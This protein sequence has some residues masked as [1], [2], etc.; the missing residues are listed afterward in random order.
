MGCV[1]KRQKEKRRHHPAV[2]EKQDKVEVVFTWK[3]RNRLRDQCKI[4]GLKQG[5]VKETG[6]GYIHEVED[7]DGMTDEWFRDNEDSATMTANVQLDPGITSL[8][9][10]NLLERTLLIE[11]S[12]VLDTMFDMY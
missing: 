2:S 5:C 10:C 7:V 3:Q 8:P 4:L 6:S 1:Q 9:K 11:L 12:S